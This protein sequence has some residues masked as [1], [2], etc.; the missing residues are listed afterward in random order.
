MPDESAELIV[1]INLEDGDDEQLDRLTRQFRNEAR[2]LDIESAEFVPAGPAPEGTMGLDPIV[3]GAIAVTVGPTVLTKFLEFL[4]AWS[5]RHQ[6][7]TV[8]VEIQ[9]EEGAAVKVKVPVTMSKVEA[10]E[11]IEMVSQS[12]PKKKGK[13]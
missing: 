3:L 12:L 9:N 1:R 13:K 5:M 8:E 7:Q 4:H 11:W 6:S 10:K 2:E